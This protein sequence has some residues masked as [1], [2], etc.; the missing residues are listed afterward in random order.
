VAEEGNVI[1]REG[2]IKSFMYVVHQI[3][4]LHEGY[5]CNED[6]IGLRHD[7]LELL[8]PVFPVRAY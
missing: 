5:Q 2:L 8:L 4:V 7:I 3:Y 6:R 1:G